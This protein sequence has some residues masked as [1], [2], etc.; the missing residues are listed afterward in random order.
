MVATTAMVLGINALDVN[1]AEKI[2]VGLENAQVIPASASASAAAAASAS[3]SDVY[4]AAV[5]SV[6]VQAAVVKAENCKYLAD[7]MQL[8]RLTMYII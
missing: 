3:V 2:K 5:E 6:L 7:L 8:E 1:A 4:K